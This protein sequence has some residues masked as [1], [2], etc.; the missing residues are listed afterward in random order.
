MI[1]DAAG[2]LPLAN[3]WSFALLDRE[4]EAHPGESRRTEANAV[5]DRINEALAEL[6]QGD[7][8][9]QP[10]EAEP[11]GEPEAAATAKP[12]AARPQEPE[13]SKLVVTSKRKEA[14][15]ASKARKVGKPADSALAALVDQTDRN[16][17]LY[18]E[19]QL[20]VWADTFVKRS[21]APYGFKGVRGE[22]LEQ[23]LVIR[24]V[25]EEA[26]A[27]DER[28]SGWISPL[29]DAGDE[30]RRRVQDGFF[31]EAAG[32]DDSQRWQLDEARNWYRQALGAAGTCTRALD[33]VEEIEAE[34][35]YYGE[36]KARQTARHS[37][38][39]DTDFL[40]LLAASTR[41]ARTIQAGAGPP[42]ESGSSRS[43]P[44]PA[45]DE[46]ESTLKAAMARI[47]DLETTYREART[48]WDRLVAEFQAQ[49]SGLAS[50][51]GPGHWREIDRVLGVP[52]IP[53]ELR[54]T[55]LRR[56][57]SV[58]VASTLAPA[59]GEG[60]ATTGTGI[61]VRSEADP[62]FW[63]E[64]LA[65]ARLDWGVLE[66][67]GAPESKLA[68]VES[69]FKSARAAVAG[70]TPFEAFERLSLLLRSLRAEWYQSIRR[71]VDT[72]EAAVA[73]VDRA[74]R[75]IPLAEAQGA[76][77]SAAATLDRFHRHALLLWHGRRLLHD[78]APEHALRLFEE[79]QQTFDS[80]A[81]RQAEED[82]VA[83][84]RAQ[85]RVKS[86][87]R[88]G[89]TVGDW[90]EQPFSLDVATIGKLPA[91]AAAV[92][93]G[94][95][96]A[97][98]LA[99]VSAATRQAARGGVLFNV[100][101]DPREEPVDYLVQR[102]ES[103]AEALRVPLRLG[104]FY[105]G[106]LFPA[107]D[108]VEV[109]LE[110]A[111]DPV[112]VTVQQSYEG[113]PFKDFTDQFK[114]HPGQGYLHYGTNLKY[115]L[116]LSSERAMKVC[117]RYGL[118]EHPESFKTV[119]KD[120]SPKRKA[121]VIDSVK[122]NDFPIVKVNELLDIA[123]L[124]LAVTVFKD[125]ENGEVLGKGV[126][127]FRMIPPP[128]YISVSANFEPGTRLL[129]LDVVHLANDP[130]TGPVKVYAS[131]G[132]QEGWAWI[133]RSRFVTFAIPVPPL[134]KKVTWRVGVE[135]MPAAFHE[136]VETPTPQVEEPKPP[137][138]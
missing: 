44:G 41:L 112:A 96:A 7:E 103:T 58:G 104:A 113:L 47:K 117:V 69:A 22:L 133:R 80:E 3:P 131:I 29:V 28:I 99:V 125:K 110:S 94:Y 95:D 71:T 89:I 115:K 72:S 21:G 127:P 25:A 128:R 134:M 5:V 61:E 37:D 85:V 53:R 92:L 2:G 40:E 30:V 11:P 33:L 83:L 118:K 123:P 57:R 93:I 78:F 129:Y 77:D 26:A 39:L 51:G 73:A 107:E 31:V 4:L 130:V 35:P 108:A 82:A 136:E 62:D 86:G 55:L 100:A 46:N 13:T 24:R 8:D 66:L 121:D 75:A 9:A 36:W 68:Q 138:L 137:A 45:G 27:S 119:I 52:S 97:Q 64:A 101:P 19:A 65:L 81:A 6:T 32:S 16:R 79:A 132:G 109:S 91:G 23:A 90:T 42:A 38:G 135:S 56:V 10:P 74:M 34:L 54:R 17:P 105:R 15:P 114:E 120:I 18:V 48:R 122:G 1:A 102:T 88:G 98:P 60:T 124:T 76:S 63:T 111:R 20:L 126:Y 87:S 59:P 50:A 67:A 116:V 70:E 84:S 106:R 43:G 14:R 49:A 12:E